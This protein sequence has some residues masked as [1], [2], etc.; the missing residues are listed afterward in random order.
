MML[1]WNINMLFDGQNIWNMGSIYF[2][3]E[4]EFAI[5]SYNGKEIV[6]EIL[7]KCCL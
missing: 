2:E 7:I 4:D 6:F 5:K 1:F 3:M